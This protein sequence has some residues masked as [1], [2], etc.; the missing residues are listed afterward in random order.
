MGNRIHF[1]VNPISG[2]K[3]RRRRH[4]DAF[5]ER[6]RE[7]GHHVL[8]EYTQGPKDATRLAREAVEAGAAWLGVAGGD[9]TVHEAVEGLGDADI[10]IFVIPCGTENVVAKYL[11][12]RL[13]AARLWAIHKANRVRVF[14]LMRA[15]GRKVLFSCGLG[16][17]GAVIQAISARRKGHISYWT[18]VVPMVSAFLRFRSADVIV[19]VDGK[20]IYSGPGLV[21]IGKVPRYALG[22]KAL[23]R[24]DPADEWIDV[25]VFPRRRSFL[26]V[27]DAIR[28]LIHPKWRSSN[29][30]YAKGKTLRVTTDT[31]M[32][33]QIDGELAGESP[34]EVELTDRRVR[35]V[36]SPM[37][38]MGRAVAGPPTDA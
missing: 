32:P 14:R 15:N 29:T 28:V 35:F 36:S 26:L 10:P 31:P 4:L 19:T 33:V 37:G 30:V 11:G 2:R 16:L 22:M 13:N 38:P 8:V 18:Y 34:V 23:W 21:L 1:I 12:I 5:V 17:D 24:A 3:G 7:A 6:L 25:A 9:G 20:D 27:W